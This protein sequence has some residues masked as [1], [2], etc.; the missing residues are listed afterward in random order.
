MSKMTIGDA[1]VLSNK[2][3]QRILD[4]H[5]VI[6]KPGCASIDEHEVTGLIAEAVNEYFG[7][8]RGRA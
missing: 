1:R 3:A 7:L 6:E 2:I 8:V 4:E 5:E